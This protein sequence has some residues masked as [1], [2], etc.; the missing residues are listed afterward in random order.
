MRSIMA[1]LTRRT[2]LAH[3]SLA[4]VSASFTA[5]S[6]AQ[7]SGANGD[8]R[9]AVVGLN[10]KGKDHLKAFSSLPGVRVVALCD[11]DSA[12]LESAAQSVGPGAPV[13]KIIDYRE[14]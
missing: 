9:V 13:Q 6:W 1:K 5:R 3:G 4:G 8:V 14:L 2:F 11:V 7:I 10:G 12:V